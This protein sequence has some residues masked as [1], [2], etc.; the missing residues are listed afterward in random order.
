M[1]RKWRGKDEWATLPPL[2]KAGGQLTKSWDLSLWRD[3]IPKSSSE[4]LGFC[5]TWFIPSWIYSHLLATLL[6]FSYLFILY[7][8]LGMKCISRHKLFFPQ[9][10]G[11]TFSEIK[12]SREVSTSP[13]VHVT[14]QE[15][16]FSFPHNFMYDNLT[17]P[18][19]TPHTGHSTEKTPG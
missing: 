17:H 7:L 15:Q 4:W 6:H 18:C 13:F 9:A 5:L 16:A 19:N 10:F 3:S 8:C 11:W 2:Q 14:K 12:Y 1:S